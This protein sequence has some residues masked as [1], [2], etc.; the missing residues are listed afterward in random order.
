MWQVTAKQMIIN[1]QLAILEHRLT[2]KQ[3]PPA[4]TLL[5]RILDNIDANLAQQKHTVEQN[6][7]SSTTTL[8]SNSFEQK[9]IY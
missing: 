3:L 5:D 2:S 8:S 7:S 1:E 6:S 9:K 4:S